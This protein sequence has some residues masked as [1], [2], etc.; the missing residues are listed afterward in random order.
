MGGRLAA[1]LAAVWLCGA[2]AGGAESIER[3]RGRA[4]S[5][6]ARGRY[7]EA[8]A[9]LEPLVERAPRELGPDH[10]EI[11][12]ILR[13]LA[14]A[15]RELTRFAEAEMLLR[16]SLGLRLSAAE[17]DYAGA[18]AD[19]AEVA[20]LYRREG[21]IDDAASAGREA[22]ELAEVAYGEGQPELVSFV[23][24]LAVLDRERGALIEAESGFRQALVLA[25]RLPPANPAVAQCELDLADVL[26][27]SSRCAEALGH[28]DR[29]RSLRETH[30]GRR[31]PGV[32]AALA[33]EARCLAVQDPQRALSATSRA[34]DILA[35]AKAA[36]GVAR[37]EV[38]ARSLRAELRRSS[39][40]A[41]ATADLTAA[42]AQVER[43]RLEP[44]DEY[45]ELFHRL[46]RWEIADGHIEQALGVAARALTRAP[47]EEIAAFR[48]RVPRDGLLLV[49]VV[50]DTAGFV[51]VVPPPPEPVQV[52]TLQA[53]GPDTWALPPELGPR[54]TQAAQI[55]VVRDESSETFHLALDRPTIYRTPRMLLAGRP[56]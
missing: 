8:A 7:A 10:P 33:G 15:Y 45:Q 34:I 48:E 22:L 18:A 49:S 21:R 1:I 30:L 44:R 35:R 41:Q 27:R 6:Q 46:V 55:V 51:F 2:H 40:P 12:R 11:P 42:V 32:A 53:A 50:G 23:H 20:K 47:R 29:A 3:Q 9:I 19:T 13:Q 25:A 24:G 52:A 43:A 26:R 31:D 36:P 54:L 28:Y 16:G 4:E 37:A 38:E 5:E 17:P 39:A 56:R 14:A